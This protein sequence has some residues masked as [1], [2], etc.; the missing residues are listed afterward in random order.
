MDE[1]VR[2]V[3][4]HVL[5]ARIKQVRHIGLENLVFNEMIDDVERERQVRTEQAS[6]VYEAGA[7]IKKETLSRIVSKAVL[8]QADCRRG[9]VK[10]DIVFIFAQGQLI[11]VAAAEL[12]NRLYTMLMDE[13]IKELGL[14]LCQSAIRP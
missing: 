3:H 11:A 7:I 9:Y 8:A 12:Y 2:R 13:G 1:P 14:P 6:P 4:N 10:A 5:L